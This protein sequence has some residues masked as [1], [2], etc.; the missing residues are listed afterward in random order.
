MV[1]AHRV[2]AVTAAEGGRVEMVRVVCNARFREVYAGE[3]WA[4]RPGLDTVLPLDL[5]RRLGAAVTFTSAKD[6]KPARPRMAAP[7]E[8]E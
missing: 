7:E 3:T 2:A 1:R 5:A 4:G 8:K 6:T